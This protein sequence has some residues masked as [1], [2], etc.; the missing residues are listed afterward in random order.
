M[1]A[2]AY[3]M[4]IS[5]PGYVT[6]AL[7]RFGVTKQA[8]TH[9]GCIYTPPVYGKRTPQLGPMPDC[10]PPLSPAETTEIQQIVGVFLFYARA[11]DATMLFPISR[12]SS[13]QAVPTQAVRVAAQRFLQYAATYPDAS[14]IIYPS[15]M[16]LR[17]H[18]DASYLSESGSRSRAGGYWYL[19]NADD[20]A[21]AH[22]AV[23]II[24]TIIPTVTSSAA[25][26]EYV[27][28]YQWEEG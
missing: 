12:L 27:A 23:D 8:D 26:T 21:P 2:T 6:H 18:I 20:D 11:V 3:T 5:M 25:E 7:K 14:T 1:D 22:A 17:A 10:S 9:S 28:L 13:V 16:T 19:G 24:C 15:A 4:T